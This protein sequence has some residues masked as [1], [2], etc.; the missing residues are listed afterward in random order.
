MKGFGSVNSLVILTQVLVVLLQFFSNLPCLLNV[1]FK[2]GTVCAS[3]SSFVR[4]KGF[5]HIIPSHLDL[6]QRKVFQSSSRSDAMYA[7]VEKERDKKQIGNSKK[8]GFFLCTFA[9]IL[10][11]I[12]L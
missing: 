7:S 1:Y 6:V 3:G 11:P 10:Y 9:K 5:G 2:A 8:G 4:E 12:V